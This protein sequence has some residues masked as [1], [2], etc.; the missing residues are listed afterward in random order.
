MVSAFKYTAAA[1]AWL[2]AFWCF[3]SVWS[4]SE[5]EGVTLSPWMWLLIKIHATKIF[6]S[7]KKIR[8]VISSCVFSRCSMLIST[9]STASFLT[10]H[11]SVQP[12][13]L[14]NDSPSALRPSC[15]FCDSVKSHHNV[16]LVCPMFDQGWFYSPVCF[17]CVVWLLLWAQI[18]LTA[19]Q[20]CALHV[21]SLME[22]ARVWIF[23]KCN[24]EAHKPVVTCTVV[25]ILC[26]CTSQTVQD[27]S[28]DRGF[29]HPVLQ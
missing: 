26:A 12:P 29:P 10:I 24:K 27:L 14:T 2:V 16:Q 6:H 21:S 9:I 17:L 25:A 23:E 7:E 4:I 1:F 18:C 28:Q 19:P 22:R 3:M 20:S 8:I 5:F 11:L 13:L 15:V